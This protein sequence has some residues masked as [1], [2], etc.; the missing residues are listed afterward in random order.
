MKLTWRQSGMKVWI[1]TG[2]GMTYTIELKLVAAMGERYCLFRGGI[3][4]SERFGSGSNLAGMKR[5]VRRNV[6][7]SIPWHCDFR[8]TRSDSTRPKYLRLLFP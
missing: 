8:R 6:S 4:S 7:F 3:A 2:Y 5:M 1:G